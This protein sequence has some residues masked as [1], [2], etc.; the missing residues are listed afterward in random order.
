MSL[1]S[2]LVGALA[3]AIA[4]GLLPDLNANKTAQGQLGTLAGYPAKAVAKFM[5]PTVPLFTPAPASSPKKSSSGTTK[6]KS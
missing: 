3:L 1:Q 4:G 5:D 6:G 2:G